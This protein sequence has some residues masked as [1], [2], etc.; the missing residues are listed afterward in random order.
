MKQIDYWQTFVDA[1]V[2]QYG[3][4]VFASGNHCDEKI[5]FDAVA[6]D[7]VAK[8]IAC[9]GLAKL[10]VDVARQHGAL[11]ALVS[12]GMGANAFLARTTE[13]AK[14]ELGEYITPIRTTYVGEK[15]N[16]NFQWLPEDA[17]LADLVLQ[18]GR[19]AVILEDVINKFTNSDNVARLVQ[20]TGAR[21]LHI[22][23]AVR[24]DTV[25]VS[26]SGIPSTTLVE[27][28]VADWKPDDCYLCPE[29]PV[30]TL[31]SPDEYAQIR[32]KYRRLT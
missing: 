10:V 12:V 22:V 31:F 17:L 27:H 23:G 19:T 28:Y 13:L 26:P 16:R 5:E 20:R 1:G 25:T 32:Q 2:Q 21:V 15:P 11:S 3:H 24:R 18:K 7:L 29:F 4:H 30:G 8:E 14:D 9:Q 6:E